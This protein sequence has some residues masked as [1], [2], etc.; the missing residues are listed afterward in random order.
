MPILVSLLAQAL[1]SMF[2]Y[3]GPLVD[4]F[5]KGY[6]QDSINALPNPLGITNLGDIVDKVMS[7]LTVLAVPV[8]LAMIL[9]GAFKI[10]T[11][12]G[13][14]AKVKDGGNVIL[15]AS[16]GFGLLLIS[17]GIVAI[18]QSLFAQ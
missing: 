9:Y 8:V 10:I 15:W 14:P 4:P 11:S 12:A 16:V 7:A 17:N 3:Q 5:N 13:D 1:A 2:P 18:I 6:E